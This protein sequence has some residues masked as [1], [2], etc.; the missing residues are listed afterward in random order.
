MSDISRASFSN[1]SS[2]DTDA[3]VGDGWCVAVGFA[4]AAH[5]LV[6]MFVSE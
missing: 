5:L 2:E 6:C 3:G 1:L 4:S